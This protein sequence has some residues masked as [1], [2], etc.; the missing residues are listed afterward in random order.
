MILIALGAN[1]PSRYGSPEETIKA[2]LETLNRLDVQVFKASSVWLTAPVP[3]SD[4]PYYRNAVARVSS[5]LDAY[6][7]MSLLHAVEEDFGRVRAE[8]NAARVLDLD[9]LA[10]NDEVFSA[11]V[12][13]IPHPRMHTRSFVL[14]PLQEVAP[15]WIHPVLGLSVGQM[16]ESLPAVCRAEISNHKAA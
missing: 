15:A 5:E 6:R 14:G 13:E 16:I 12:L 8:K 1:L 9:L 11:E 3:V 10:Y 4:Q 2:A 7:L